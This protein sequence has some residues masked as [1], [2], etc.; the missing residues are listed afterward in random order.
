[1]LGGKGKVPPVKSAGLVAPIKKKNRTSELVA[2]FD[3]KMKTM[4]APEVVSCYQLFISNG[5][6]KLKGGD[7]ELPVS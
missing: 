1:M 3:M 7:K 2:P 5:F 6:A 4:T